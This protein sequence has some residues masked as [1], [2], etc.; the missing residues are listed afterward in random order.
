[1]SLV[2]PAVELLAAVVL[3]ERDARRDVVEVSERADLGLALT[4][5]TGHSASLHVTV[6]SRCGPFGVE[7]A[8]SII[9]GGMPIACA[10]IPASM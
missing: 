4:P 7:V 5:R 3:A 9:S 1:M 10:I 8:R 2:Q 6:T